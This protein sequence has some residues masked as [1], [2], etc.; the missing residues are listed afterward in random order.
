MTLLQVVQKLEILDQE[1]TI[2]AKKPWIE[3]SI[4]LVLKEPESGELPREA[5]ELG[6]SYFIEV[7]IANEFLEEWTFCLM[8]KATLKQKCLRLIQYTIKDA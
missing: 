8:S 4:A 5:Q 3:N 1:Y 7:S 6:L 2:Y